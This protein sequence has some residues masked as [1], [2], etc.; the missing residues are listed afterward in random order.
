MKAYVSCY[1]IKYQTFSK[2][3]NWVLNGTFNGTIFQSYF[4]TY[5]TQDCKNPYTLLFNCNCA[6]NSYLHPNTSACKVLVYLST[7]F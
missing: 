4:W 6:E 3:E 2:S 7:Y 1:H 5:S